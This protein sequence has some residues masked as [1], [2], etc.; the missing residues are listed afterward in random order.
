MGGG[1]AARGAASA[2][3]SATTKRKI[4]V[5]QRLSCIEIVFRL[6][7][8]S[9]QSVQRPKWWLVGEDCR[10]FRLVVRRRG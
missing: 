10:L 4:S 8:C 2:A 3:V 6:G 7:G 1:P 9:E 5:P